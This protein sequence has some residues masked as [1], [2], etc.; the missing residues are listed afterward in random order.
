[1]LSNLRYPF[2]LS[3]YTF[4]SPRLATVLP[5]PPF[6]LGLAFRAPLAHNSPP[7]AFFIFSSGQLLLSHGNLTDDVLPPSINRSSFTFIVQFNYSWQAIAFL[8]DTKSLL[9]VI[10]IVPN[11]TLNDNGGLAG[12][13]E[14]GSLLSYLVIKRL[15]NWLRMK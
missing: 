5:H 7:L 2:L 13:Q 10:G 11:G 15:I 3:S 14:R 8:T 4:S 12:R 1:M 9:R 6:S